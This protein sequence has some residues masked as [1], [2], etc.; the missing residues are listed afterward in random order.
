MWSDIGLNTFR[1]VAELKVAIVGSGVAGGLIATALKSIKGVELVCLEKVSEH[2]HASAGNGLNVGPNALKAL[3]TIMPE[4]ADELRGVSLPWQRWRCCLANGDELFNIPLKSVAE[5]DGVRVRWS[6][7]YKVVR[8]SVADVT[9]YGYAVNFLR[10]HDKAGRLRMRLGS[11][12]VTCDKPDNR[13]T[14]VDLLIVAEGRYSS[15]REMLCGAPEVKH[16]GV[17]NFRCLIEDEG[18]SGV[19][20]FEQ[21]YQGSCRII[22]FRVSDGRVY[23]SGNLPLAPGEAI[24][25][26]MKL[27]SYLKQAYTPQDGVMDAVYAYLIEAACAEE[28]QHHW[29][30]AQ[31]IDSRFH[32]SSGQVIFVGDAAHAMAPTLGQGATQAIE[33]ACVFINCFKKWFEAQRAKQNDFSEL[34]KTFRK[35]RETRIEFVKRFSWEASD[36]LLL[37]SDP[38]ADN[39]KKVSPEYFER[40]HRLYREIDFD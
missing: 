24:P 22:A 38:I 19:D 32:D 23:V 17:A 15:I 4:K 25:E 13:I 16:L 6:E 14:D 40:Y 18:R 35:L 2:A 3:D 10:F 27:K 8:S 39:L 31:E 1:S 28:T 5:G 33:D 34:S 9:R 21:W 20:D 26:S 29:A 30:R 36:A 12:G 11:Q 37:G 7:L